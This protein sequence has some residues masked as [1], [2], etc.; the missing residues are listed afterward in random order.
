[1]Q[2]PV[3]QIT[4]QNHN[5]SL[6]PT[7]QILYYFTF[8]RSW[9]HNIPISLEVYWELERKAKNSGV[10]PWQLASSKKSSKLHLNQQD[11]Y[12]ISQY[13]V[14]K[15]DIL[16][17]QGWTKPSYQNGEIFPQGHSQ[18]V[19]LVPSPTQSPVIST[20][21]PQTG[22]EELKYPQIQIT[23]AM[24]LLESPG[25]NWVYKAS[26][27]GHAEK[28]KGHKCSLA[29]EWIRDDNKPREVRTPSSAVWSKAGRRSSIWSGFPSSQCP[30]HEQWQKSGLRGTLH[31]KVPPLHGIR[32]FFSRG[33]ENLLVT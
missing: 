33:H 32:N 8:G 6:C 22:Q 18:S 28:K 17:C 21:T 13:T 14:L 24:R 3:Q 15:S 31:I 26:Q 23:R 11:I 12:H 9:F 30:V 7:W 29:T 1:M 19:K 20:Q 16:L 27:L 5:C 4:S 10:P 25:T 2:Q